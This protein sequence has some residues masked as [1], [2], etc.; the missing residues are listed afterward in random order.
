MPSEQKKYSTCQILIATL[1]GPPEKK[2]LI[3]R[4]ALLPTL[5]TVPVFGSKPSPSPSRKAYFCMSYPR[6]RNG[7]IVYVKLSRHE[8]LMIPT[9]YAYAGIAAAM[10]KAMLH[11]IGTMAA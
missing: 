1:N 2:P 4:C 11:H 7:G 3:H 8:A 10:M 6:A 9:K 5:L